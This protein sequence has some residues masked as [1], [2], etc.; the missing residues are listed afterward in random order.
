MTW[1]AAHENT[2]TAPPATGAVATLATT[3]PVA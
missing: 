2:Q 3:C 1:V